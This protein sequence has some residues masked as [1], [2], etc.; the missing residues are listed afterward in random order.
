MGAEA[1][2]Q[3]IR[4][5]PAAAAVEYTTTSGGCS[6]TRVR[7]GYVIHV[8]GKS[9]LI[10]GLC[11]RSSTGTTSFAGLRT[12]FAGTVSL[13]ACSEAGEPAS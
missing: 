2:M 3:G 8:R 5:A 6:H 4:R 7:V 12:Q 1:R 13:L 10:H 9:E 11:R